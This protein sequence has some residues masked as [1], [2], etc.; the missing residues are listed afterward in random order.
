MVALNLE[1]I[2]KVLPPRRKPDVLR[3]QRLIDFLHDHVNLRVQSI[4]APAG[5]GKTTLLVDFASDTEIPLCWYSFDTSDQDLIVFF[6]TLLTSVRYRFPEFGKKT[7]SILKGSEDISKDVNRIIG[8]LTGE[9]YTDIPEFFILVLEDFHLVESDHNLKSVL[10]LLLE[11]A[12]ANCHFI[13][14]SRTP[15]EL[16]AINKLRLQ[17][18]IA[19]LENSDLG[20]TTSE[21]KQLLAEH[22][23]VQLSED[24][25]KKL[26][27]SSEGWIAGILL[28]VSNS[29][30]TRTSETKV[31]LSSQDIFNYLASEVYDKQP[32]EIKGFLLVSSTFWEIEPRNC[33]LLFNIINSEHLLE[34]VEKRSLFITRLEGERVIYRYHNLFRQFLQQKLQK[35]QPHTYRIL[36]SDAGSIFEQQQQWNL[37]I[38]HYLAIDSFANALKIIKKVGESFLKTGKWMTVSRWIQALPEKARS[39]EPV[40]TLLGAEGLIHLGQTDKAIQILNSLLDTID[41]TSDWLCAGKALSWR[42]AAFRLTG[43]FDEAKE[44]VKNA[45]SILKQ[46]NGPAD[47]L[48]DAYRRL[49]VIHAEQGRP[50]EAEKYLKRSLK[51][52]ISVFDV[53]QIAE[54]YNSLGIV[55]KRLGDLPR[56]A[57]HYSQARQY[58]E[59]AGNSGALART[60]NNI[61]IIYRRQG[62]YELAFN[63]LVEGLEKARATGYQR[64]EAWLLINIADV[65]RD[66]GHYEEALSAYSTALELAR[67]VMESSQVAVATAGMGD[68]YKFLGQL[69]K[70]EVFTKEALAQATEHNQIYDAGIFNLQLGTVLYHQGKYK[71]A[72]EV[73]TSARSSMEQLGDKD[74]VAR[75]SMHLAQL[76]YLGKKN[77][78]AIKWLQETL[79][80]VEELGYDEFM[81]LEGA[82]ILPLFKYALSRQIGSELLNHVISKIQN[83]TTFIQ[84]IDKPLDQPVPNP[85]YLTEVKAYALGETQV[86]VNARTVLDSDWRS[87]KAKEIFFYLLFQGKWTKRDEIIA[88]IW[89]DMSPAKGNSLFHSNLYRLRRALFDSIITNQN[90]NYTLNPGVT[91]WFDVREFENNTSKAIGYSR[92]SQQ[93]TSCLERAEKLY[94]GPFL[95][96]F[97]SDWVETSRRQLEYKYLEV[98]SSLV[99]Y[100]KKEGDLRRTI[101]LLEKSL[102]ID[103][104]QEETY[105]DLAKCYLASGDRQSA[106]R[107]CKQCTETMQE[108]MGTMSTTQ[109]EKLLRSILSPKKVIVS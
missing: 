61:G 86:T 108:E 91:F 63:T 60:L 37:A 55:Y 31:L 99:S 75:C 34:E 50:V 47:V 46:N 35:E 40:L 22:Y 109:I 25:A 97:Y 45:I 10:D 105:L 54:A 29:F 51:L 80:L 44:D 83:R 48:G 33:N 98:L 15:V 62:Q 43:H 57:A 36:H 26:A 30:Q 56:S 84:N 32:H 8:V 64:G 70:A 49:G 6:D 17:R 82:R 102:A 38:A 58:W 42:S 53:G 19:R 21:V 74:A 79:R 69:D 20:F 11:R 71:A 39:N 85:D 13:I 52:F 12:P 73:L 16:P 93:W 3:R 95:K 27:A 1:F 28:G 106:L 76:S 81:V 103:P 4:C 87:I 66:L 94:K 89:P 100:S 67:Q 78:T 101:E 90:G 5:Y 14:T 77:R 18:N 72:E 9:M 107:I 23:N 88:F 96:E 7:E 68:C 41:K 104:S 92:F 2:T 65:K 59:K 24:D